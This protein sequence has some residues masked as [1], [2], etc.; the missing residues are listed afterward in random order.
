MH[1][2]QVSP[3]LSIKEITATTTTNTSTTSAS[4]PNPFAM[5]MDAMGEA[6]LPAGLYTSTTMG[7]YKAAMAATTLVFHFLLV[8]WAK[9]LM[10]MGFS[11]FNPTLG[12]RIPGGS[13]FNYNTT[14]GY[15]PHWLH[16][17]H[18]WLQVWANY[19]LELD[20]KGGCP[21]L[22][23]AMAALQT[24]ITTL[25]TTQE[26]LER[27]WLICAHVILTR[28]HVF[29]TTLRP[30]CL[31]APLTLEEERQAM[32]RAKAV[33]SGSNGAKAPS[34]FARHDNH[35][36]RD[37]GGARKKPRRD[38][39]GGNRGGSRQGD[40]CPIHPGAGHSLKE[41]RTVINMA[42]Q[43]TGNSNTTNTGGNGQ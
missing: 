10:K 30:E 5:A 25:F 31:G 41:C 12:W 36:R 35:D 11:P 23:H 26:D 39:Q 32:A 24:T 43:M 37:F 16:G 7:P 2:P 6:L 13:A 4:A 18:V 33:D 1:P 22:R 9:D 3:D 19:L 8:M 40:R 34:T 28:I 20:A 27:G 38:F 42:R 29:C 21:E 17:F 14:N 15:L